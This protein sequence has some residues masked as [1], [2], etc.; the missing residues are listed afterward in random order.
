MINF[1]QA[2]TLNYFYPAS[3]LRNL[4]SNILDAKNILS[5]SMSKLRNTPNEVCVVKFLIST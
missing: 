5:F 4:N 2:G 1:D 3:P